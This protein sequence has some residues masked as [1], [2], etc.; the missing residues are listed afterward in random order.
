MDY[1][2]MLKTLLQLSDDALDNNIKVL[3]RNWNFNP[4]AL[5]ILEILDKCI[6]GSLCDSFCIKLFEILLESKI[7]EE[8]TTYDEVVKKAY[9]RE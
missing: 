5:Q 9:W 1:E 8:N 2:N 7:K 3:I 4:S 6:Y